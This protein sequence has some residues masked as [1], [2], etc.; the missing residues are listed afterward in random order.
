[1]DGIQKLLDEDREAHAVIRR[2][3]AVPIE[4]EPETVLAQQSY[5][6]SKPVLPKLPEWECTIAY[7]KLGGSYNCEYHQGFRD[8]FLQAVDMLEAPES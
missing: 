5:V 3:G 1:M 7:C 4:R 2:M 6:L 8:G